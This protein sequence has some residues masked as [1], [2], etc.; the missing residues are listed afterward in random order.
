[1]RRRWLWLV[2]ALCPL[3]AWAAAPRPAT[4]EARPE[5]H[6]SPIDVAVLPDGKRALVANHTADSVSLVDLAEGKLLA[7]I[8]CGRKPS[9]IACSR[10]GRRAAVSNLWGGSLTLL[11]ID[12]DKVRVL[13]EVAVGHL[14]RGIVFAPDGGSLYV[15]LSGADEVA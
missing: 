3:F 10:D 7:E 2:I 9:A 4:K 1:M 14:P 15:A 5:P 6:R 13:G 12:A 8:P 11:E